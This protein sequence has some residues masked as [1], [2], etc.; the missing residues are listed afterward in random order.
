VLLEAPGRFGRYAWRV[1]AQTLAYAATLVPEV[2]DDIVAVDEAMRLGYNWKWGPFELIDRLGVAWL[3]ERLQQEGMSVPPLLTAALG[4]PFYRVQNGKREFLSVDGEYQ[5]IMR[6]PGVLLLADIKLRSQPVARNRSAALWDIGDGIAC[7]EFTTKGNA[8]D[9]A[10]IALLN[11]SV[12]IVSQRFKALV[13]YNEGEN[14]SLGANLGLALF[15]ANIAAW[16]EIEKLIAAGQQT[17]RALKYAPFPVVSAPAGMALGGGCEI[18]LQSDAVQA[19]AETYAGLV[20][21]GVGLIPGWGGTAAMLE[22]WSRSGK[23]PKGPMPAVAKVF[24]T[25]S[26]AS[27][28]KSA[29]EAKEMLFLR[30]SDGISMNRDRLLAD[31]KERALRMSDG[32]RAPEPIELTLPGP[33]GRVALELVAQSFVRRGSATAND[34]TVASALAEVLSGG[35]TDLI[36][37]VKE[38]QLLDLERAGFMRLVKQLFTLARIEHTLETGKPLRN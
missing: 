4:R 12:E 10:V 13:I 35:A 3:I 37:T 20:E 5:P 29:A 34:F 14:F 38:Q 21:C 31:A 9:D 30:E 11:K 2:V 18:L 7:F 1:L 22:R 25:M 15:A 28:A 6:L 27:V 26:T 23:L 24:E 17:Y 8:L 36:D 33:S 19:H 32:Y 16:G